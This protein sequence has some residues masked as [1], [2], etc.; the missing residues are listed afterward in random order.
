MN[1]LL[2]IGAAML[3]FQVSEYLFAWLM[4]GGRLDRVPIAQNLFCMAYCALIAAWLA[5][6]VNP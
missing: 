3:G 4:K 6:A 2:V 1:W 5:W